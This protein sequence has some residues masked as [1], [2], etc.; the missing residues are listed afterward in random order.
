MSDFPIF[1]LPAS[2][3][4][5]EVTL[6]IL[7]F[8]TVRFSGRLGVILAARRPHASVMYPCPECPGPLWPPLFPQVLLPLQLPLYLSPCVW[9]CTQA[10]AT[11]GPSQLPFYEFDA[12]CP[13]VLIL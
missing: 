9:A 13:L 8:R 2:P 10:P 6:A 4:V 7:E 3:P 5:S 12:A 1:R 11:R